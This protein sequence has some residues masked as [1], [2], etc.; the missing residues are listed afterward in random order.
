MKYI[1]IYV[2]GDAGPFDEYN[3]HRISESLDAQ[4]VLLIIA[5]SELLTINCSELLRKTGMTEMRVCE[6]V[7]S[8][9][10]A[11]F[12][13]D[14]RGYYRLAFPIFIE[15]DIIHIK[16]FSDEVSQKIGDILMAHKD[17]YVKIVS[18][19]DVSSEYGLDRILYHTIGDK[20]FDGSALDFFAD[21]ELFAI[22][23]AQ[24]QERNYL[25]IGYENCK[26]VEVYSKNLLCSS[27]NYRS[28]NLTFNS[29]GDS[30]GNRKDFYRYFRR[31]QTS[32]HASTEHIKLNEIYN[33]YVDEMNQSL[34]D[35]C[36]KLFQRYIANHEE[37]F[38]TTDIKRLAFLEEMNYLKIH[39][40][41]Y[42]THK[43]PIFTE[44]LVD[45]VSDLTLS[46]IDPVVTELFGDLN[47]NIKGL[48]SVAH[49]VDYAEIGNELWH[50]VFGNINEY[51]VDNGFFTSLDYKEGEGRYLKALYYWDKN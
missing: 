7:G 29:F 13:I 27:N 42:V 32:I 43:I 51:L 46:L 40:D 2:F 37:F 28:G 50:Q 6:V 3:P 14:D 25:V 31:I 4:Q 17:E 10:R 41:N 30:M 1:D 39:D 15:E 18:K 44:A 9:L 49:N 35:E 19:Y 16:R 45:E 26:A 24:S 33:S 48:I 22:S 47:E 38:S 34:M 21:K 5:K 36:G 11:E 20:V 12:I 8:L 23:K